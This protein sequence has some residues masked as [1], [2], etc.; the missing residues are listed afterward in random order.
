MCRFF[1]WNAKTKET[2][3]LFG[4][5][6]NLFKNNTKEF[7]SVFEYN[8]A[9]V[10]AGDSQRNRCEQEE[11]LVFV[12]RTSRDVVEV[13]LLSGEAQL[14][15]FSCSALSLA[16]HKMKKKLEMK[17]PEQHSQVGMREFNLTSPTST[18]SVR[19]FK[20]R[21]LEKNKNLM[22]VLMIIILTQIPL[23]RIKTNFMNFFW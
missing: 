23:L 21:V 2:F 14:F 15:M 7:Q 11:K 20:S 19:R 17:F 10:T 8:A 1:A 22:G 5:K 12:S 9:D 18:A 4:K 13:F 16:P 3:S 6:E